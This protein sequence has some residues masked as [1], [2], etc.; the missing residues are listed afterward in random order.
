MHI[1][2]TG[3]S[4]PLALSCT[5]RTDDAVS[6]VSTTTGLADSTSR[7]PRLTGQTTYGGNA[8][9]L[10]LRSKHCLDTEANPSR[11]SSSAVLGRD[12]DRTPARQSSGN[13]CTDIGT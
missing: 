4:Q 13:R 7:K 6:T 9:A 11:T 2:W 3:H 5:E 1:S 10:T 12:D 8:D